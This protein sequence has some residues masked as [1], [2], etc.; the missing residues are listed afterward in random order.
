MRA[1]ARAFV[2]AAVATAWLFAAAGEAPVAKQRSA[3]TIV[4]PVMT[5]APSGGIVFALHRGAGSPHVTAPEP[6]R[7]TNE[8]DPTAAWTATTTEP[9]LVISPTSGTSPSLATISIDASLLVSFSNGNFLGAV[10]I[11]SPVAPTNILTISVSLRITDTTST[12]GIPM[13]VLETPAQ[14]ATGLSGAIAVTGWAIDDVGI[15]RVQIY[16]D[17]VGS[18]PPG[19]IFIG[20]AT[21]VRGAR[22]DVVASLPGRPELT[23]AG[24]GLMVL[25]NVLPN[26]GNGTFTFS[27]VAED[28]E[29]NRVLLGQRTVTFDNVNSPRP[30][31]TIDLPQQGGT[32]SGTYANQGWIL[33]QPTAFVPFDG[34]TI[35]LIIDGALQPNVALYGSPRPDVLALFP[36]P[37]YQNANGPAVQF[38]IDTTPFANG[39][40]TIVWLV[41]DSNGVSQGIG[42][43]FVNIENGSGSIAVA[44]ESARSAPSVSRLP[45]ARAFVW[46]RKGVDEGGW[47]LQIAGG[48]TPEIR[49]AP[50]ERLEIALDT[51][52]W[53]IGC[54]PYQGYLLTGDVAAPLPPGASIDGEQGL[55][56]WLPPVEFAGTFE[57]VF[58]RRACTGWEERIPL[59]VIIGTK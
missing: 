25:S 54:G 10:Q 16:R 59:R 13:G 5:D 47:S 57:F 1:T 23:S 8:V 58:I 45:Q 32:M 4:A 44:T 18:E 14:N 53:S 6:I 43:R 28:I 3:V 39:L 15:R 19:Q 31:G 20:D 51:W 34:S 29:G 42:S 36:S 17:A 56:R 33:A 22:P 50:G 30:F 35:R 41:T 9:W 26:G 40:H 52:W 49:Q 37:P 11:V 46:D 2:T 48:E 12:T 21:R 24:W 55:F 38:S 27:A 7:I